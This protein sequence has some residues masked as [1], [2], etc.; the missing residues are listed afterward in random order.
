MRLPDNGG[1]RLSLLFSGKRAPKRLRDMLLPSHQMGC[2]LKN[3]YYSF[4]P[5]LF[6]NI[7]FQLII[8]YRINAKMTSPKAT[9]IRYK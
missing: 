8:A 6:G 7:N 9:Y 1:G 4:S 5:L 2:S 3:P